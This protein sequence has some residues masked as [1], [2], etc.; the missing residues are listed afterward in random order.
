VGIDPNDCIY[1]IAM[2]VVEVESLASSK[3]FLQI[4]KDGLGIMNTHPW[5]PGLSWLMN[6]RYGLSNDLLLLF[7]SYLYLFL[8]L[9]NPQCKGL[10]PK[11]DGNKAGGLYPWWCLRWL[12]SMHLMFSHV[13]AVT[14]KYTPLPNVCNFK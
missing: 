6:R 1:L 10:L 2:G 13:I 9:V 14:S 11:E 7:C 5:R 8:L 3:W 4:L 12:K